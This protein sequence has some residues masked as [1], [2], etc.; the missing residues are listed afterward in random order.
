MIAEGR[1]GREKYGS[2]KHKKLGEKEH[3]TTNEEK[4][5]GKAFAMVAASRGVRKKNTSSLQQKSKALRSHIDR[6]ST[7][8]S[9]LL[10]STDRSRRAWWTTGEQW[11]VFVLQSTCAVCRIQ[12]GLSPSSTRAARM[13]QPSSSPPSSPPPPS[14][15]P[16]PLWALPVAVEL[17]KFVFGKAQSGH[18]TVGSCAPTGALR[19][20][21]ASGDDS[22]NDRAPVG[23]GRGS[24]VLPPAGQLEVA[25][26]APRRQGGDAQTGERS[27]LIDRSGAVSVPRTTPAMLPSTHTTQQQHSNDPLAHYRLGPVHTQARRDPALGPSSIPCLPPPAMHLLLSA[28]MNRSAQGSTSNVKSVVNPSANHG[29]PAPATPRPASTSVNCSPDARPRSNLSPL[30]PGTARTRSTDA[31]IP[32]GKRAAGM[33][34]REHELT[35]RRR[36]DDGAELFAGARVVLD[37]K[38]TS[39]LRLVA[40]WD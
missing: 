20:L 16:A 2:L 18:G 22:R 3:S 10:D 19:E 27:D 32:G 17:P 25:R 34:E 1:E 30:G 9:A 13:A 26:P 40:R 21:G 5:K 37:R 7:S 12:R 28:P 29:E 39:H 4:R 31:V 8:S 33:D 14:G 11:L 24:H 35:K 15:Q 6:I 38:V 23:G 36:Y